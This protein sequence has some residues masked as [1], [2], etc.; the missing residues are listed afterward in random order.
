MYD[1]IVEDIIKIIIKKFNTQTHKKK[2]EIFI[3]HPLIQ[4]IWLYIKPY[5]ILFLTIITAILFFLVAILLHL[6][7]SR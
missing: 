3:V 2:F 6:T 1:Q 5:V 7:R 4:N